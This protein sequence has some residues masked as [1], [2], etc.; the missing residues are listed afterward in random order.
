MSSMRPKDLLEIFAGRGSA[1]LVA[2]PDSGVIGR[3]LGQG[4]VNKRPWFF[5]HRDVRSCKIANCPQPIA[6]WITF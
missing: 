6:G 1:S 2:D 4:Q 3:S 5:F